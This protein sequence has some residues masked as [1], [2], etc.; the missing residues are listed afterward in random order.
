VPKPLQNWLSRHRNPVS[1]WLHMVGIPATILAVVVAVGGYWLIGAALF[2]A[3]YALQFIGHA[4]EGN[5][6]GEEELV[7]KLLARREAKSRR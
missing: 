1:F 5:R 6:S 3:G 7:R 2:V 4:I